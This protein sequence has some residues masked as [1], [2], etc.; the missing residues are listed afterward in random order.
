MP[1]TIH[2]ILTGGTIDSHWDIYKD[3]TTPNKKSTLPNFMKSLNLYDKFL[4]TTICMK[5]SRSLTK[6]DIGAVL[7]VI[8][9]SPHDKIIVTHGTFTMPDT[10]RF[11]N[12]NLKFNKKTIILTGSMVPLQGFSPSDAPFSLGY[13]IS[14]VKDLAPGVYICMNARVF[15]PEEAMKEINAGRFSS[16]QNVASALPPVIDTAV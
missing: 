2:F 1:E 16:N 6:N 13:A 4:F 8:Q 5:D 10:A 12:A 15:K 14:K 11:L 7:R 3:A 9:K